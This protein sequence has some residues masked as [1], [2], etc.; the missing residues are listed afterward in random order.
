MNP[1][2]TFQL[3]FESTERA[4]LVLN[5]LQ[6][7]ADSQDRP[8]LSFVRVQLGK[9]M[10]RAATV[11]R[12][13]VS[14]SLP[15]LIAFVVAQG[16][17]TS[18]QGAVAVQPPA[19]AQTPA[20]GAP[21]VQPFS[22]PFSIAEPNRIAL[23]PKIDGKIDDEE[24][25]P[26]SA[27]ADMKS[28]FQWEPGKI[29]I[30]GIV[31]NGHDLVASIDMKSNGWLIGKDN[32]EIR[33]SAS[34]ATPTL[35]ARLLDATGINGPQWIDLPGF[36]LSSVVASSTDG[37]NTTYEAAVVD[38][39]LGL[40]ATERGTKLMIRVDDPPSNEFPPVAYLPRSLSPVTL[41]YERSAALPDK[42][43]FNPEGNNRSSVPGESVHIRLGFNGSNAMKLQRLE[44]HTEG[45]A[46][47]DTNQIAVPFPKFDDRG[48]S[49]T[50]YNSGIAEGSPEGYRVLK[51][52]L[53]TTDGISGVLEC[54]YR[55]GPVI[56]IDVP[57]QSIP[58]SKTDRSVKLNFYVRSNSERKV[59]GTVSI[60]VPDP[61][62]VLNGGERK[63]GIYTNRGND[64]DGFELFLP[65]NAAGTYPVK[66]TV[67]VNGKKVEQIRFVTIGSL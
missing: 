42:L 28:Y 45:F 32:L 33:L 4:D 37:T 40:I 20:Q 16:S 43:K 23:T 54:S 17:A 60:S 25:D 53:T 13:Y 55:V 59:T 47:N 46:K 15:L 1:T 51:G 39:G 31:P 67:L 63:F 36:S 27:S 10:H 12:P 14:M 58:S 48:R 52:T 26:L 5:P 11:K 57:K 62:R 56:D 18:S 8:R 66:F 6:I 7:G 49:Y 21:P 41:V 50:D 38:S 65:A 44:V 30:A 34:G 64:R 3:S 19:Q 2:W 35:S 24:W 22:T 61:L 9:S 29:F